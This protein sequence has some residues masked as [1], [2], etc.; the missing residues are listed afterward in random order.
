ME[1]KV[2]KINDYT[3][4]FDFEDKS[5]SLSKTSKELIDLGDK[6]D[7]NDMMKVQE[8]DE[9]KKYQDF[10]YLYVNFEFGI[11]NEFDKPKLLRLAKEL[12]NE[13]SKKNS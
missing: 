1:P 10:F 4:K 7:I 12:I 2:L 9:F 3:V 6:K 5:Y 13:E 8:T 11:L